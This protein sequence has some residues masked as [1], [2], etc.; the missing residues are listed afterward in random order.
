MQ[1]VSRLIPALPFFAAL[2]APTA[3]LASLSGDA[4]STSGG[5]MDADGVEDP[6][7]DHVEQT[8]PRDVAVPGM[9]ALGLA[10]ASVVMGRVALRPDC[11][12][13]DDITTC[14]APSEGDIGVRGGRVFGAIGF[15]A[16]G[17]AFGAI[18]GRQFGRWLDE[19]PRLSFERKHRIALGTGTTAVVLGSAGVIA[20]ATMLGVGTHRAVTIGRGFEGDT[21][22][23]TDEEYV[24]LNEGLDQVRTARA[25]LML[26]VATPTLLATGI[27][28]LV[29]RPQRERLTVA[30]TFGRGHAGLDV[31]VRF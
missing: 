2:L 23:L 27:S 13:Q 24:Q 20:G 29:H 4:R 19:H 6:F 12:R 3:A 1:H 10:G 28:L 11:G 17:A 14:T 16:G 30:P 5:T 21:E 18:A 25:G 7:P 26:L 31:R 8:R 15:G 9:I 22:A